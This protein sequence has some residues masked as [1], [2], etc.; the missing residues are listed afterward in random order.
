MTNIKHL[1][2]KS[3]LLLST[4]FLFTASS[5]FAWNSD[6]IVSTP[7]TSLLLNA[8]KGGELK[9]AY[10]GEK[11][12]N[13]EISQIYDS[14]IA[15]RR[16]AYP[17]FGIECQT[18]PALSVTHPDGNMSLDLEIS[19]VTT[20]KLK[21]A[22]LT[23]I[24]MKDKVYPFIVKVIYKAFDKS[25]VI[26]TWT[27]IT[28][29]EKKPVILRKFASAYLPIRR[30]EVWLSHL[31][32]AWA[33]EGKLVQEELNP[34][35]LVI[36]N[37][38]GV[39]NSQTDHGEVMFS[40]DGKPQ[41]DN[42]RVIGAA[43]CWSGNYK[44]SIDT[45]NKRQHHFIAGINEEN[46]EYKLMPKETF[47]T[48]ELALTYSNNGLS[49][50]SRN[51][52]KWARVDGK[53]YNGEK[54]R[55][56]LLNSWEGV[57]F[58]IN[59]EGMDQM[60]GDISSMGGELFVM[61]DGWFGEKYPRLNGKSSLGDWIVDKNKLPNGV[62]GLVNSAKKHGIKFGIWIEPEMTNT[63]SE[64]YEKHPDWVIQQTNRPLR[65]GR[66]GSQLV[67]DVSNPKVQDF[68]FSIVDNLMKD[69]P[70]LYYIKWDANMS[71]ANWG[72]TYLT[73]DKQS[74]LMIDYH[75][76]LKKVL[77]RIRAKYPD[78]VIQA[79]ASGGGRATYGLLPYFDEF[80]VSDDTDALQRI[81]MQWGTSYF[82]PSAAM[83]SH[84][85]A[86]PNHQ[87]GRI[88]PIKFRFDVAM[89]GRLGMEIQPKNMTEKEKEFSKKAIQGYK[90]IRPI[91]QQGDLYRL[92]S[93]Y[94]K[95]GVSSLMYSTEDKSE[96]VFFAYKLEHFHNQVIPRFTMKGLDP[97]KTYLITEMNVEGKPISLNG[98]KIKG[99]ILMNQ[100]VELPLNG[101][102][103]SHV[104]KLKAI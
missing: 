39:R 47:I 76:G 51:F 32:G 78:L 62:P 27:E 69:N 64:L 84:V 36:K 98:K 24:T 94:D 103:A 97:D 52:H 29:N 40:L 89:T 19:D 34:G 3:K 17:V 81:Y 102:Y 18:E 38:D 11:L 80:W 65:T 50:A 41:E 86:A 77:E 2:M 23:T 100:G 33:D 82:F 21:N 92:I 57:Y 22:T 104:L 30:G 95:K 83:A 35:M 85:S 12:N 59:E 28:N 96:A 61:D 7:N 70:D 75:R 16:A 68:I 66:G 46:S 58:D 74:H 60:M 13:D 26:E 67:L 1:L 37:K 20:S 99:S 71:V 93:P 55:D 53:L 6:V 49:G 9:I 88:I 87:T 15:T 10:Y 56:I 14:G 25:D 73:A 8:Q 4:L 44:L 72:S 48:P 43:L 45:D 42:G 90:E 63:V 31:H 54:L 5:L 79:C 91:V 101:E